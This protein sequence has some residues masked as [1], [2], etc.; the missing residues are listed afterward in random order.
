MAAQRGFG[1]SHPALALGGKFAGFMNSVEGGYAYADVAE[2]KTASDPIVHRH[3][4]NVKYEDI[5]LT[6]GTGMT[7]PFYDAIKAMVALNNIRRDG[8]IQ[9]IDVDYNIMSLLEFVNGLVTEVTFPALDGSSK[10]VARLTVKISPELTHMK[11]GS[12]K[13]QVAPTPAAKQWFT[14]NFHLTI[15]GMDCSGVSKIEALT[16]KQTI[17]ASTVGQQRIIQQQPSSIDFPNLVVTLSEA[18]AQNFF[19]WHEDFVIN[20]HSTADK[21]KQATL[22]CLAPDLKSTLF[23]L[24]FHGLGIFRLAPEKAEAGGENIRRVKAEMYCDKIDFAYTKDAASG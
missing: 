15:P 7:A 21:L 10:D 3:I 11:K 17:T 22:E 5:T 18:R 4:A 23:T 19:D 13:L 12:G 2:T 16:I 24:N 20:G 9:L 8:T 6:C 14:C 1:I